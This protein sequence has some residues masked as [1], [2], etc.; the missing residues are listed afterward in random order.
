M[1][2]MVT[3]SL[4]ARLSAEWASCPICSNETWVIGV[5]ETV[6]AT[7]LGG[8]AAAE[9]LGTSEGVGVEVP[10]GPWVGVG[11]PLQ[12]WSLCPQPG[13]DPPGMPSS[14]FQLSPLNILPQYWEWK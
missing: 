9:E 14:S 7:S 12:V 13:K 6:A 8:S 2:R 11:L 4:E 10:K 5:R 3:S 1:P